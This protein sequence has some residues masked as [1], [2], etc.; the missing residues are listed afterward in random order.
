MGVYYIV[1]NDSKKE[2][3]DP[4]DFDEHFKIDGIFQGIHGNAIAKLLIDTQKPTIYSYGWWA[5]DKIRVLGDDA[6]HDEHGKICSEYKNISHYVLA[7]EFENSIGKTR[8][9]I[10]EKL[11]IREDILIKVRQV[12]AESKYVNLNYM[13]ER[14]SE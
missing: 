10:K 1:V 3:I 8:E 4:D 14:L 9:Q 2:Y 12:N 5:K 11:Q 13:L 7:N 6:L